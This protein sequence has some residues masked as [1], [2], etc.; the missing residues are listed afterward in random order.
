MRV[1]KDDVEVRMEIPG[2]VIRQRTEFGEAG[3]RPGEIVALE[4]VDVDLERR[5]IR[6]RHSDWC[7]ELTAPRNGRIRFIGMTDRLAMALRQQRPLRSRRV[8]CKDDGMP[9]T[10]QGAWSRVRY[11]AKRAKVPTGVHILR[12]TFCSHL[13][14]Q[15]APMRGVQELVLHQSLTMTAILAPGAGGPRRDDQAARNPVDV[16]DAEGVKRVSAAVR[17]G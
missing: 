3:L 7:G 12:H 6:V 1:A 5:Q 14:M 4:W 11:A 13:A 9:L 8:L 2:A 15:G 16:G 10:R 17:T